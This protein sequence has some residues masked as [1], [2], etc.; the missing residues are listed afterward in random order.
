MSCC[1]KCAFYLPI[2]QAHPFFSKSEV[3]AGSP[4]GECRCHPP[5]VSNIPN[6]FPI[7]RE[8]AWCGEF[9]ERAA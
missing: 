1:V 4:I 3:K 8:S 5:M 2:E 6:H 9:R 7:V